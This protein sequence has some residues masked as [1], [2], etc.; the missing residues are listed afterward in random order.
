MFKPIYPKINIGSKNTFVKRLIKSMAQYEITLGL[1]NY[2][3]KNIDRE[4]RDNLAASK[5]EKGKYVRDASGKKL[6]VLLSL[7]DQEILKPHD[8]LVPDFFFGGLSGK[9]HLDAAAEHVKAK[10]KDRR[11]LGLDLKSFFEQVTEQRV[12]QFFVNSGCSH[13]AA[14]LLA[15]FCCVPLGAKN[16][17]NPVK[18]LGRGFATS[19]RLALWCNIGTFT[20]LRYEIKKKLKGKDPVITIYV[21][22]ISISASGATKKELGNVADFAKSFLAN[23][24]GMPLLTNDS[25]QENKLFAASP[26]ILGMNPGR[27]K[28]SMAWKSR[29]KRDKLRDQLGKTTDPEEKKKI[30]SRLR[31]YYVYQGQIDKTN[32]KLA[33]RENN[34]VRVN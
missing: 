31:S 4:W 10:K 15:H 26:A 18:T 16:S 32:K 1:V 20:L 21:D 24:P 17:G 34:R 27:S 14:R 19:P 3:A 12:I 28:I 8:N 13:G 25:K 2:V 22:D 9:N 29:S 5:P 23:A 6:G 7:I 30:R 11:L 33:E